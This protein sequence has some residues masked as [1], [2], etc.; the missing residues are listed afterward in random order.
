MVHRNPLNGEVLEEPYVGRVFAV[1]IN[2]VYAALPHHGI[3]QADVFFEMFINDYCTRGLASWDSK[4]CI[5]PNKYTVIF[6]NWL[7]TWI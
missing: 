1:S 2:N 7:Q 5:L 4:R 6:I 3:S